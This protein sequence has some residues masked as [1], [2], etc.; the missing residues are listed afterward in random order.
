MFQIGRAFVQCNLFCNQIH[1]SE[2]YYSNVK[3]LEQ[4]IESL[5][6]VLSLKSTLHASLKMELGY[7]E[8]DLSE[9]RDI[10]NFDRKF[11]GIL[12]S[13]LSGNS[14]VSLILLTFF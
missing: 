11:G 7:Q 2:C 4:A 1:R 6:V 9:K 5:S 14:L 12:S 8:V 10:M 13:N 3:C